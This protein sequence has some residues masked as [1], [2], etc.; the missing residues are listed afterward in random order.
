MRRRATISRFIT[1][2]LALALIVSP[3]VSA[4]TLPID[5]NE[6]E[7][8]FLTEPPEQ[9]PQRQTKTLTLTAESLET[10]WAKNRQ[11]HYELDQVAAMEIV[12]GKDRVRKL[13]IIEAHNIGKAWVE[14]NSVQMEHIGADAWICVAS[15]NRVVQREGA[16]RYIVTSGP[17]MRRFL[18]GY[19]PMQIEFKIDYP[20]RLRFVDVTPTELNARL[21]HTA[22]SIVIQTLFEGRL[23]IALEFAQQ[24]PANA[25]PALPPEN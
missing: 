5:I 14:N 21:R 6:G 16:N 4:T 17:F 1:Q 7:L 24:T 19:F 11:C 9:P 13:N 12:F 3:V 8:H 10:G 18:D 2:I 20:K 15:E 23:T 25:A 22:G